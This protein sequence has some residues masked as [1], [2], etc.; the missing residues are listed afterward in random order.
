M[1]FTYSLLFCL[2]YLAAFSQDQTIG[3]T[4]VK[5]VLID[6][7]TSLPITSVHI[8]TNHFKTVSNPDGSFSILV[9]PGDSVH[10]SHV[11][12]H[13]I[14]IPFHQL[15]HHTPMRVAMMQK[16][17]LLDAVSVY[18]LSEAS[19]KEKILETTVVESQEEQNA[20]TNMAVLNYYMKSLPPLEMT[21]SENY[22]EYMKGPQGVTIFSSS[23]QKGLI[24]A[25]RDVIKAKPIP[26]KAFPARSATV[27]NFNLNILRD[28]SRTNKP[29]P[30]TLK[31]TSNKK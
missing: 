10:F 2:C 9:L 13:D 28:S 4:E 31:V 12:Y 27:L 11:S 5:G 30:D 29:K 3:Y 25:I 20:K 26:Y 17:T 8:R 21:G 7:L 24:K 14:I 22:R 16:V 15:I 18:T 6:S 23:G 19:F 1:R